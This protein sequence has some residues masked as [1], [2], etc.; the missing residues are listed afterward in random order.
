MGIAVMRVTTSTLFQRWHRLVR[1]GD[2]HDYTPSLIHFVLSNPLVDV[3]LIGMRSAERVDQ[4]VA[5]V[6]DMTGR[7]DLDELFSFYTSG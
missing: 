1:P 4:N 6:E 2:T 5:I 3:A 7:L